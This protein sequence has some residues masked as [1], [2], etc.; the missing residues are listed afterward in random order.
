MSCF[1]NYGA[2]DSLPIT[3]T[4]DIDMDLRPTDYWG[5]EA[6]AK[7]VLANVKGAL[8]KQQVYRLLAEGDEDGLLKFFLQEDLDSICIP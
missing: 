5:P 3:G 1:Q 8:R 2:G 4:T 6:W 7:H